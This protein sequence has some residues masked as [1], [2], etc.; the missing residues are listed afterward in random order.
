MIVHLIRHGDKAAGSGDL[1]L[2]QLGAEQADRTG[3]AL[4]GLP[5]HTLYASPLKRTVETATFIGRHLGL[6]PVIDAA[7]RERLIYGDRPGETPEEYVVLFE[8]TSRD[9][10]FVP[11]NGDSSRMAGERLERFVRGLYAANPAAEFAVATHGGIIIDM[12]ANHYSTEQLEALAPGRLHYPNCAITTIE[13]HG[14]ELR[15]VRLADV[16]HLE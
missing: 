7:V 4:A 11:P 15:I 2:S 8:R 5:I 6:E 13:C 3:R 12:L 16:S 1:G 9:R 10:D 14:Q